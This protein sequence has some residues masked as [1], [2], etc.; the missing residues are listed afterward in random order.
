MEFQKKKKK[1]SRSFCTRKY[2]ETY[3]LIYSGILGF[4][5]PF[6]MWCL[7]SPPPK[8]KKPSFFFLGGEQL[9]VN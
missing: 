4:G 5:V 1:K 2:I 7:I 3:K 6:C 8:K 9:F